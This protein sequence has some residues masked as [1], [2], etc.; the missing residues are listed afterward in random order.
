MNSPI[1]PTMDLQETADTL[2]MH[3]HLGGEA[4]PP[5]RSAGGQ[6]RPGLPAPHARRARLRREDRHRA[7][8]RTPEPPTYQSAFD[9]SEARRFA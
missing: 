7:D 9:R 3:P 1:K 8:R 5:G 6:G 4:D 2:K